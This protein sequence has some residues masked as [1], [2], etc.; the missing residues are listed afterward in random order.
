MLHGPRCQ[1]NR[2]ACTGPLTRRLA[3]A[4]R[5]APPSAVYSWVISMRLYALFLAALPVFGQWPQFRGPN[6]SGVAEAHNLP[7]EF[8]PEK[9]VVW[10]VDVPPGHSSPVIARG[11]IFLTAMEGES[12]TKIGRDN[13]ADSG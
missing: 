11:R 3:Y 12:L 5:A 10:S 13:A 4:G 9:N 8:G 6:G 2:T 1:S 7:V